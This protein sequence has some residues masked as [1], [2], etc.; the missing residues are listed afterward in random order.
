MS[1]VTDLLRTETAVLEARTRH[2]AAIHDQRIAAAMLEL[3]AGTLTRGFGGFELNDEAPAHSDSARDLAGRMR[4]SADA[5]SPPLLPAPAVAVSTVTAA[6]ETWPSIYEATGTV[7]ARTSA[8]ISAKLMGYVREVKV[9]TGDRVREGQLLVTLDTRDLD[10]SSRR[11]EA[12]REEV[13]T[14]V[15]EADSAVAAA[16]ANLDLAQVT[17]GRMQDLFQKT[18]ISNQ[19]FDEASARLKAA[20]AAYDMAQA[21]RAQ[22][23]AK[24]A[25]ADQEVRSTEVTRSYADVLAPFAGVVVSKSVD[26]GSL[27]VPGA[28]L[29]TIER[30]GAYRLEASVEESHLAA[31][32]V[33]QP[34]SVTLDSVDRTIEARVSEIVP[35]VDAASRAYIVKIDLPALPALRSGVFGRAA[36]QLGSRSLLAIPAAAVTER[37]QLQSV[38]VADN[39][40]AR[41]RLITTGQKVKDRI[42]V[43]SGLT[44]GEKVIFPVPPGLSDGATSGGPAVKAERTLGPAGKFAQAWIGSKLTP[45]VIVGSLLLG[46]F[47][48]W[49]LP[50]EEEPQII[51]PM[52]DVFVQMP[53]ASAR[54]VEERVTKP[55]EKLLWEIPGVEYIYSTSSPGMSTAIV[56]FLVGQDEEKSI[57]RLNQKLNANLDLIPPGASPPLVKPRSIDDVP[58]LALT[59]WSKRYG[60]FELRR[61]AAQVD[62]TIK[63]TPDVSAVALIGGQRREIRITLDP[64]APRRLQSLAVAGGGGA[65][66]FQPQDAVG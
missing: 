64:V 1:N 53:G 18:S 2:L 7:R 17:F 14:A 56:R 21:R 50:R 27:A 58:I 19:E 23:N 62:D 32:R 49:K 48:V 52:V 8:V 38:L 37:G 33:G 54:E 57:V 13:R 34:V 6:T 43:L 51:V 28:P 59:F 22:L 42:E 47:A 9:Q 31:I 45:L 24:L 11:A 26:P 63:Q 44:A 35:A 66:P 30:E 65:G 3:A 41:T 15:P 5:K 20:Q 55:M 29:L 4:R 60:D 39:G 16:K 46:A 36:F 40:I 61:I 25:Q 10:V 12:A